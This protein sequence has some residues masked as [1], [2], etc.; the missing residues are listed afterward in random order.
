M[1]PHGTSGASLAQVL[2]PRYLVETANHKLLPSR[3]SQWHFHGGVFL[4]WSKYDLSCQLG[5]SSDKIVWSTGLG[6]ERKGH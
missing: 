1:L 3:G 5:E 2:R 6:R 4:C